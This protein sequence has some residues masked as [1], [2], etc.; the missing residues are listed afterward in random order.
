MLL[1]SSNEKLKLVPSKGLLHGGSDNQHVL[2]KMFAS[3]GSTI[4]KKKS[5]IGLLISQCE[6]YFLTAGCGCFLINLC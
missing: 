3:N 2:N 4:A 1:A 5:I 6:Q